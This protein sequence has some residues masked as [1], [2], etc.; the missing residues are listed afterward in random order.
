M[1]GPL[2]TY[3]DRAVVVG[4]NRSAELSGDGVYRYNLTRRWAYEA[5]QALWIMCNPSTADGTHDDATIR[6]C[7]TFTKRERCGGFEVRNLFA[8]RAT[9]I[10]DL[11]AAEDEGI[12]VVGPSNHAAQWFE[13]R[14]EL[15]ICAWGSVAAKVPGFADRIVMLHRYAVETH[16]A[17]WCLGTN[18]DGQPCHPV[19][20]GNDTRLI[21]YAPKI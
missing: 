19:R 20:L 2:S 5:P 17:L 14:R 15:I 10:N 13:P 18:K 6:R 1:T 4:E 3:T 11:L 16:Q 9:D 7:R 12:D 8:W 21:A